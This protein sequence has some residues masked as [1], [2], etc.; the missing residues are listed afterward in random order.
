MTSEEIKTE[1]EGIDE[2]LSTLIEKLG[3]DSSEETDT[4]E[5]RASLEAVEARSK[6]LIS[7][8]TEL[9]GMLEQMK[10]KAELKQELRSKI[11]NGE[12]G[13]TRI[14]LEKENEVEE[15][16]YSVESEE[17]RSAWLKK[18]AICQERKLFGDLTVEERDAFTFVTTNT[19]SVVPAVIEN[20][21]VELVE[22]QSPL[23]ADAT[24]SGLAQGFGVP[25]HK[26]IDAGDAKETE[27][28]KANDDEKDTF[29]LL[30]LDG[31]EIKK[32]VVISRKMKFKSIQAFENWVVAHIAARIAVAKDLTIIKRLDN[33]QYGIETGNVLTAQK[34]D[35][36]AIRGIL[37][38]IRAAGIKKVYA[39]A[40][41]IYKW[42]CRYQGRKR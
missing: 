9:E 11:A 25:R 5:E 6:E 32:H 18:L 24:K 42:P 15:R 26:S 38:K 37:A 2:E 22:S 36:K 19:P 13:K 31:I 1:L 28:G 17:Y 7:R 23:Y 20:R 39:N 8:K 34:Y 4:E 30:T 35:D 3:D 29:D 14:D 12:L 21:I 40:N 16:T 41:T 27:E 10:S 33:T